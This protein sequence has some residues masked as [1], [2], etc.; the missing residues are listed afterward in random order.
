MFF[1]LLFYVNVEMIALIEQK[2][3]RSLRAILKRFGLYRL[4]AKKTVIALPARSSAK[5]CCLE[6]LGERIFSN[7]RKG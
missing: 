4:H 2:E 5:L 6:R 7:I 1:V 3:F